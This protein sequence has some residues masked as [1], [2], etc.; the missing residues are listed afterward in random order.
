MYISI[1][2]AERPTSEVLEELQKQSENKSS[3]IEELKRQTKSTKIRL[4]T[5]KKKAPQEKVEALKSSSDLYNSI[6]EENKALLAHEFGKS[7]K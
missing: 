4:E 7:D 5:Q 6:R 2:S 1:H 3:R